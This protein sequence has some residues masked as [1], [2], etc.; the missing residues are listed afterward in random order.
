MDRHITSILFDNRV[1][2]L[3]K[4]NTL[5]WLIE[6]GVLSELFE[7]T[8]HKLVQLR[9]NSSLTLNKHFIAEDFQD[10][11]SGESK[12]I[13]FW[14]RKGVIRVA[15]HIN[16]E[17]AFNIVD[18]LEDIELKSEESIFG[19][20]ENI[21]RDRLNQIEKNGDL[22]EIENFISTFGKFVKER[23]GFSI[24]KDIGIKSMFLEL[25]EDALRGINSQP[26]K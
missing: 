17:K 25:F 24:K 1:I 23:S 18:A 8:S 16:S 21:L 12:K 11:L 3:H 2:Y 9:Q 14:S 20:L 22:K 6:E 26:K 13:Y 10:R 19:E 7:I 5:H 4:H 15:Y